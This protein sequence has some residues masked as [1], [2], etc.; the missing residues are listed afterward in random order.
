MDLHGGLA[1]C[2]FTEPVAVPL[3]EPIKRKRDLNAVSET[4]E[5]SRKRGQNVGQASHLGQ[6]GQLRS[7]EQ[8][9]HVFF[10]GPSR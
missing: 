3:D 5:S 6:R 10:I 2:G 1:Q 9:V 4:D 7:H 8:K